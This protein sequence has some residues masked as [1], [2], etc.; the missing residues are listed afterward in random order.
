MRYVLLGLT[1]CL[2]MTFSAF[3]ADSGA[4]LNLKGDQIYLESGGKSSPLPQDTFPAQPI[5]G[6]TMRFLGIGEDDGKERGIAAGL[7][8]FEEKGRPIAFAPTNAAEFCADVKF[9]PDGKILA[10][11]SGTYLI[12]SWF[13]FSFPD[14]KPVGEV[15]YYQ[16]DGKPSLI[17]NGNKGALVSSMRV[18]EHG[19]ACGYD[20]CG[21]V[22]VDYYAFA[23]Q[24][25]QRLLPGTDLC[26]YTLTGLKDDGVTVT[27]QALCLQSPKDWETFPEDDT[28]RKEVTARIP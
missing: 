21:P 20:P 24:K 10:M 28:P 27:A 7:Y 6:T 22:S 17:W 9:S 8:I 1:L 3:A 5:D 25:I 13:F 14:M 11:D 18:E 15:E 16:A 12:R 23:T 19:R 2:A 4:T 26:D